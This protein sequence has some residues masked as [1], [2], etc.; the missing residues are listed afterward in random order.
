MPVRLG[1]HACPWRPAV[2]AV[3]PASYA[4]LSHGQR[5][6]AVLFVVAGFGYLAWRPSSF[7]PEAPVFSALVYV[8]ELFDFAGGLLHLF[9]CWRLQRR[10]PLPVPAHAS[11]AALVPTSSEDRRWRGRQP[12]PGPPPF[13]RRL[14]CS[15]RGRPCA[16]PDVPER[17]A[18]LLSPR[19]YARPLVF[20]AAAAARAIALQRFRH[21]FPSP[22]HVGMVRAVGLDS[23]RTHKDQ[24]A[25]GTS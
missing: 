7:N 24:A 15:L 22:R 3:P 21:C 4:S 18:R 14:R 23:A 11:V 12:E 10:A 1:A 25:R 2:A 6:L 17:D 16:G 5:P 19:C 20:A 13:A 8:A 9:I